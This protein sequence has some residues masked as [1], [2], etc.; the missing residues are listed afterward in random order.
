MHFLALVH[1]TVGGHPAVL[2][3]GY[4]PGII[5]TR[6]SQH[7]GQVVYDRG[8][9]KRLT[10]HFLDDNCDVSMFPEGV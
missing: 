4:H 5:V 2:V 10:V 6:P 7:V 9:G 3:M 1:S 8:V